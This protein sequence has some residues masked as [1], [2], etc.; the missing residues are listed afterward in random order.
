MIFGRG[1]HPLELLYVARF[2]DVLHAD[3]LVTSGLDGI[4]PRGF[5]VGTVK[6]VDVDP[7][8]DQTFQLEL[9]LDYA[10][11]EEVLILPRPVTE[12]LAMPLGEEER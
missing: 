12:D 11:L 9:E 5:G 7:N 4:F 1:E 6:R 2:S 8:G 10:A 3:R